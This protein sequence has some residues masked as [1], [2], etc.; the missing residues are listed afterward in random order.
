MFESLST[1]E[2]GCQPTFVEGPFEGVCFV[3][4]TVG[5]CQW[6][7]SFNER[8]SQSAGLRGISIDSSCVL[9]PPAY[10][11]SSLYLIFPTPVFVPS[12]IFSTSATGL[13]R[14]VQ[15]YSEW[16]LCFPLRF[17]LLLI[18]FVRPT[19]LYAR[20]ARKSE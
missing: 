17:H 20:K 19:N 2:F 1:L 8:R 16:M 4:I 6:S 15:A 11:H 3:L 10:L 18:I 14:R 13:G 9:L 12:Q 7:R 5:L